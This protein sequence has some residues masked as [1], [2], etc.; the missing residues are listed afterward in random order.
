MKLHSAFHWNFFS[1]RKMVFMLTA[2]VTLITIL[3]G[4]RKDI[5][6]PFKNYVVLVSLDAFRWDYNKIYNTPNLNKLAHD[7]VK[8]DR[9]FSSFPTVTFPNHYSIATGLYPD[10]HGL[11]DNS[12][13]APDLGL[14]YRMGDRTAVENPSFYGGE[15]IWVTAEKQG[16]RSAS[17]FWV[18]SEAPVGGMHPTYWKKYDKTV[19]FEERIDTVIKWLGYP[20]D[21]RPELVTLYFD[22]PDA[23]SHTFGPVSPQ[24]GKVVERLDS[25]M[26]VLRLKLS[27]L[28]DAKKINLIILSDHGMEAVSPSRYISIK[29]VVPE[30]MIASISG[31][32]PVY[33]INPAD[34][35]KDSVLYLL[36]KSKGLKAWSKSNLPA[37]WHYGTNPRIPEIVVVAD[38]SWSIGTR[39]DGS[40]VKGGAHGYD[41]S[42]SDMFSIFYAAGPSF[43]KNYKFKELNNI[44]VYDLVC[45]ILNISPAKNDGDPSHTKGI[46][47]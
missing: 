41:N 28:P 37:R 23:T 47:R 38:S 2:L 33:L 31:G 5:R 18:G 29:A 43:R 45:R 1:K 7:G 8:A 9:M 24:T 14:F 22:E 21:K 42:N 34:G 12:F 32:N 3:P 44:D 36:N 27:A 16:V 11:I 10:H 26:G 6:K 30:R 25:L 17:F 4:F 19:T 15:P 40:S 46:L 35:K 20:P 39:P 13:S